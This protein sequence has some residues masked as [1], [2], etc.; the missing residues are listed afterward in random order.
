MDHRLIEEENLAELYVTGR[1]S[2]ELADELEIHLLEC[3]ECRERVALADELRDSV[4]TVAAEDAALQL[5]LLAR[6][7]RRSR[8]ARA[9]LWT[10]ALVALAVLPAWLLRDRA[11]LERELAAARLAPPPA[12]R[13][14]TPPPA[15]PYGGEA[16]RAAAQERS[17]LEEEL[18][19]ERAARQGLAEQLAQ[20]S[21]PQ[22]NA[23]VYTLGLVRGE[24]E[25]VV[26]V[27]PAPAWILLSLELPPEPDGPY[28]TT[29][30]DAGGARVWSGE[31]LRPTANDTL[32]VLFP[33][34][35]LKPGRYRVRLEGKNGPGGEIPFR[36]RR[37]G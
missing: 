8:W 24:D 29:L 20:L 28:R 30:L 19:R 10:A 13:P 34:E 21:R 26:E 36:V 25:A 4:R 27:G 32:T 35:R 31:G 12:V 5:G 23:A 2:P 17:R 14:S 16:E 18:G 3:R 6:L 22:V 9:A 11:R 15:S 37:P 1:L 33:S 7:A